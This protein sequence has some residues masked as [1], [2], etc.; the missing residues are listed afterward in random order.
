MKKLLLGIVLFF[1]GVY[2]VLTENFGNTQIN[3]YD[4]IESV[5]E[6]KAI[7]EGW[8]PK[9]LPL[10]AYDIVETHE[11][12]AHINFGRFNYKEKDEVAFLAQL[13]QS[14]DTY[15]SENFLF[16]INKEKNEVQFRNRVDGS[17]SAQ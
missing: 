10:S 9:V 12:S 5:H 15:N 2:F 6:N 8:I 14:D 3:K 11:N 7:Q 1:V 13:T 16:K 17:F 4:S